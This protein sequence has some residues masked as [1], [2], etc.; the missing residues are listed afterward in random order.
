MMLNI[1]LDLLWKTAN[2]VIAKKLNINFFVVV[3]C[4]KGSDWV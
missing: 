1:Y 4:K 3:R 2:F